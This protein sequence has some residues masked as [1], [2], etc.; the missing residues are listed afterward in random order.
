ML[1]IAMVNLNVIAKANP[2]LTFAQGKGLPE[3]TTI[4]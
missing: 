2:A 4:K 3:V 1:I